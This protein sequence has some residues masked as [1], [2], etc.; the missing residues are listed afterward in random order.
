MAIFLEPFTECLCIFALWRRRDE[1][2]KEGEVVVEVGSN[3]V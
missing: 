2:V 3:R 1:Q